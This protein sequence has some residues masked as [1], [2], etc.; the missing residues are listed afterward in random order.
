MN[1]PLQSLRSR[2]AAAGVEDIVGVAAL[3]V[4]A[5]IALFGLLLLPASLLGGGHVVAI[6]LSFAVAGALAADIGVDRLGLSDA[7][8]RRLALAFGVLAVL[9]AV[10]FVVVNYASF[11]GPIEVSGSESAASALRLAGFG[12]A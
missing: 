5:A 3:I 4:G 6:G 8:R 12:S 10:A 2:R 1:S 9:L 7:A 11:S